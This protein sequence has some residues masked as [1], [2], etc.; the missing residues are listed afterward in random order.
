MMKRS[1]EQR[2]QSGAEM[3][4]LRVIG[5]RLEIDKRGHVLL[6]AR[7]INQVNSPQ[8]NVLFSRSSY[9]NYNGFERK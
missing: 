7:R 3:M 4:W 8:S 1:R 2:L 5:I 6:L 9:R